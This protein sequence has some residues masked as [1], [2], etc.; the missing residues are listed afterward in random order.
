[1]KFIKL[2]LAAA[3]AVTVAFAE[4]SASDLGVSANVAMTSNYVWRGMTQNNNSPAVQGGF[5][6]DYKGVYAGVWGSNIEFGDAKASLETDLYVGYANEISGVSYDVGF[7]QFMYPNQSD[8]LNFGEAYVK[9]GYDFKVVSIGAA[10]YLGV[11]TNDVDVAADN[12]E[13]GDA[14]ELSLSAPLPM[15]IS[16]D[17]TYGSYDDA[18]T[19]NSPT[20]NFGDY[21]SVGATKTFDKFDFTLAYTGMD[22]EDSA[23]KDQDNVVATI[24]AGF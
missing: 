12:W 15:D 19:E 11:D 14:W 18:G 8:E 4:E 5:D 17:G 3:L 22:F 24:S 9:L 16:V 13:P 2:S 10:Y 20:N 21:Y 6:L 7:V 1:M 23:T